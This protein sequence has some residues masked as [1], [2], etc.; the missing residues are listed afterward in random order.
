MHYIII[1]TG[2]FALHWSKLQVMTF[3]VCTEF[4]SQKNAQI[5]FNSCK[6]VDDTIRKK[7]ENFMA[8]AKG[9]G[10]QR[11]L[12]CFSSLFLCKMMACH[13]QISISTLLTH[14]ICSLLWAFNIVCSYGKRYFSHITDYTSK[15]NTAN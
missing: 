10:L 4:S 8:Y 2:C 13:F 9:Q 5:Q 15:Q 11:S 6:H 3:R 1:I 12:M 7:C 14:F